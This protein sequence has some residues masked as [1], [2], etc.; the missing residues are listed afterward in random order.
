MSNLLKLDNI[1]KRNGNIKAF[2]LDSNFKRGQIGKQGWGEITIA[3]DNQ[4]IKD[5]ANS[6]LIGVLYITSKEEW[7]KE[8]CK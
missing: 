3:V 2:T 1:A 4:T 7:E 6:E 8:N 5:Y